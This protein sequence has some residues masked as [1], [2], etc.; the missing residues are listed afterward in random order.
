MAEK[1]CHSIRE[2]KRY[3]N[4]VGHEVLEFVQ[5]FGKNPEPSLVRGSIMLRVGAVGPNGQRTPQHNVPIVWEFP[6]GTSVKKAFENF[7]VSAQAQIELWKK[8]QQ[9]LAK[10]NQIVRAGAMPPLLGADG[11]AMKL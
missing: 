2:V 8:E 6:A 1:E 4:E 9:E 10:A 3:V 11:K 5:V 7:E